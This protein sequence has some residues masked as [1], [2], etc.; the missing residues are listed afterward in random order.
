MKILHID[1]S[2]SGAASISRQLSQAAV[3]RLLEHNPGSCVNYLDLV[4][5]PLPHLTD[6]HGD[7]HSGTTAL[8]DFLEA[9]VIVVGVAFYNFTIPSQLKAWIDRIVIAGRTFR[10]G[11]QGAE[12]L[13]GG[14]KVVLTIARGGHYRAGPSLHPSEHAE[15]YLRSIFNFI[16]VRDLEVVAADG[17]SMGEEARILATNTALA[18]ISELK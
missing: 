4:S 12:G 11:D 13:A 2:I 7:A 16:G 18:S 14:R 6:T 15:S 9:D 10:Y 1:T 5:H 3:N 17:V 8:E